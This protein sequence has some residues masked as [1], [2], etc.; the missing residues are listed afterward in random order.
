MRKK[1]CLLILAVLSMGFFGCTRD[2]EPV[3]V[4]NMTNE[5]RE[6]M[7]RFTEEGIYAIN[8]PK[9]KLILYKG[10]EKG[11]KTMSYAV[12]NNVLSIHFETEALKLPRAYV[13]KIHSESLYDYLQVTV[14]GEEEAF[15]TVYLEP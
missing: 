11:I 7:N 2:K 6:T 13:Y 3:E 12:E 8:N 1:V 15:I 14:D 4:H 9:E 5:I 10:I